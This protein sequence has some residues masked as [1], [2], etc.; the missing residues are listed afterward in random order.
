VT[1]QRDYQ[2]SR[3]NMETDL[4]AKSFQD[5]DAEEEYLKCGIGL[6]NKTCTEIWGQESFAIA[7]EYAYEMESGEEVEDGSTLTEEY[8][9]TRLPIV[10]DRLIAA[11]VRLAATLEA[12][13]N[14][15][16]TTTTTTTTTGIPNTVVDDAPKGTE[17]GTLSLL[18]NLRLGFAMY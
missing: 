1:M 7:L 11:G 18:A 8:Y 6:H 5:D 9:E 12:I 14:E 15:T 2:D 16:K 13:Y 17:E 10:K 3:V 4:L